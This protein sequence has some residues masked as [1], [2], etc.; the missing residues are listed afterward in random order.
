MELSSIVGISPDFGVFGFSV[1]TD[2]GVFS[3]SYSNFPI[4]Q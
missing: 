2:F 1:S 4:L 3:F